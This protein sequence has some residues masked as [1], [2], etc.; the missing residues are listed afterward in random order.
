MFKGTDYAHV[1]IPL[2]GYYAYSPAD[3]APKGFGGSAVAAEPPPAEVPF[4]PPS[5]LAL[6]FALGVAASLAAT[7]L[8]VSRLPMM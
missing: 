1:M 5:L 3:K 4:T 6:G 8:T 7:R 2:P